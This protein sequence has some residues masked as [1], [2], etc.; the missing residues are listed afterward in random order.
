M[1]KRKPYGNG[2]NSLTDIYTGNNLDSVYLQRYN[3]I[4][5]TFSTM[6]AVNH[7]SQ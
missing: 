4:L 5:L 3:S 1:F 2:T 6:F 7:S